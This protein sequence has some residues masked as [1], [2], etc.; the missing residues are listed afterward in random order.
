MD[1]I[2]RKFFFRW[3][4]EIVVLES[5]KNFCFKMFLEIS[6]ECREVMGIFLGFEV[7]CGL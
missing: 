6:C 1:G 2:N 5:R 4:E 7:F 3:L